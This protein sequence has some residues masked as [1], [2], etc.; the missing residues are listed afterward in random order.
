[1]K[2]YVF[3]YIVIVAILTYFFW[4][5]GN[6]PKLI[7][8]LAGI[9]SIIYFSCILNVFYLIRTIMVYLED[10]IGWVDWRRE[11]YP[12]LFLNSFYSIINFFIMVLFLSNFFGLHHLYSQIIIWITFI[13]LSMASLLVFFKTVLLINK[14]ETIIESIE[15]LLPSDFFEHR[16]KKLTWLN[17]RTIFHIILGALSIAFILYNGP[18]LWFVEYRSIR[19][20]LDNPIQEHLSAYHITQTHSK[21][22]PYC[23]ETI[24]YLIKDW[25]Q[26]RG[27]IPTGEI[28]EPSGMFSCVI[29]WK[30]GKKMNDYGKIT[31]FA[32]L[33]Y[34]PG[35]LEEW[36]IPELKEKRFRTAILRL[37][38]MEE[39]VEFYK[40]RMRFRILFMITLATFTAYFF[41][42]IYI[43][44]RKSKLL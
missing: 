44:M 8:L 43:N 37:G 17:A 29:T 16:E 21:Y 9:E 34:H 1:M 38:T 5:R 22:V 32:G 20:A 19:S 36:T 27:A 2:K 33:L 26:L 30:S 31:K 41:R 14:V 7:I 13:I 40:A 42:I 24:D 11:P 23:F 35:Y 18:Y 10:G 15:K 25:G 4:S 39:L 12:S 3:V 6:N 28:V